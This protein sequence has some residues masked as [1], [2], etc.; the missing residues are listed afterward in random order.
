MTT[1]MT[2]TIAKAD[3]FTKGDKVTLFGDWDRRGTVWYTQAIVYSCGGKQ[4][5]LTNVA[6]GKELGA[7]FSPAKVQPRIVPA[8]SNDEATAYGLE[9]AAGILEAQRLHFARCLERNE[10][11]PSRGYQQVIERD[12]DRLHEPRVIARDW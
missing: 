3:R 12:R 4:M 8:M 7:H 9:L 2:T 11:W 1:T 10:R 5:V 6:S